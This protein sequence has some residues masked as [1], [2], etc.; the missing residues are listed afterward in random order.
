MQLN[1]A[2]S[3]DPNINIMRSGKSPEE[4]GIINQRGLNRKVRLPALHCSPHA[5][6]R[7]AA[8]L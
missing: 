5:L 8:R 1:G 6:T 2:V 4:F 7:V 3:P